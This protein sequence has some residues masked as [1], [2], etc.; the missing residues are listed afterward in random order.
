V[1]DVLVRLDPSDFKAKAAQAEA[2]LAR[3]QALLKKARADA[4]RYQT[5]QKQG[6]VSEEKVAELRANAEAAEAIVQ[7]D[8]AALELA[9]LQIGYTTLRAPFTGVVGAKLVFPG[10]TVKVNETELVV[11]NRVRPLNVSFTVP[12]KYL[13]RIR[14]ALAAKRLKVGVNVPEDAKQ[15]F[16]GEVRFID[17][18]VDAATGTIR[19]KAEL[20]NSAG[21][22][23]PGQFLNVALV[24]D[25]LREAVVVP[26]EAIQQGP[27]GAFVFLVKPDAG[28]S[29]R[30]VEVATVRDGF[31]VVSKGLAAGDTVVTDGHSRL[32]P[33]AKIKIRP[34]GQKPAG[35]P[36][37]PTAG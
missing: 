34:P 28:T 30:K 21:S 25:T 11:L 8:N 15:V 12:E 23:S 31:A 36:T 22:L 7:A 10:A 1:G 35:K 26:A 20:A 4:E 6:F 27:D 18:T 14:A 3:D 32:V 16:S 33:G 29:I 9:R 24:L 37:P 13:P 2:N 19:M 17:N 5:L